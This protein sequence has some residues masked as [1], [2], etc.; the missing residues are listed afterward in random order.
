MYNSLVKP[1]FDFLMAFVIFFLLLPIFIIL[2]LVLFIANNGSVF[3][4]HD[5]PG[6]NGKI[7]KVVKFKTMNDR[8]DSVGKLLPDK[9]RITT[10]G[11]FVR[12]YSLDELPQLINVFRGE[13]SFVG[14]RPLMVKYLK[15]Y[16]PRQSKRHN[17]KPGITGWAQVNGRNDIEWNHKLDLDVWYVENMSA[18]LD[19]KILFLTAYKVIKREG[20]SKSG[21]ATTSTWKGNS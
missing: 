6:L 7:F 20:V 17:V 15:L 3:Y 13:M 10:A 19:F 16:N 11:Q 14:P 18:S 4:L 5:R 9:E 21:E 8:V 1:F 2:C 12:N